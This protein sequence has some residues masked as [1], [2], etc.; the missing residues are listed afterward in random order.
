VSEVRKW[1]GGG[2][3]KKKSLQKNE[4]GRKRQQRKE[5]GMKMKWLVRI[6]GG[7]E[8]QQKGRTPAVHFATN[9]GEENQLQLGS[10]GGPNSNDLK[11]A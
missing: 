4:G 11:S 5:G 1:G 10:G 3:L 7:R 8:P 6:W 9:R 2:G